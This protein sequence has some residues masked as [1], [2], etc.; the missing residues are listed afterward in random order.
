MRSSQG[1]GP[2]PSAALGT[3]LGN[4]TIAYVNGSLSVSP[5]SLTITA[6]AQSK[7]YGL[8]SNLGTTAFTTAGLVNGDTVTSV[9]LTGPATATV[10][11]SPYPITGS[12]ATGTE[13]GNYIISYVNGSLTV[14]PAL[15]TITA[16]NRSKTYRQMNFTEG[17]FT[18]I[19]LQNSETVGSV[20][21][22]SVRESPTAGVGSYPIVA[23]CA[24]GGTFNPANHAISYVNGTLTVSPAGLTI[25]SQGLSAKTFVVSVPTANGVVYVLESIDNLGGTNWVQVSSLTGN[26]GSMTLSDPAATS[27]SRFY[28]VKVGQ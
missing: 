7:T 4:Y 22:T 9:N 26:G 16:D 20:V 18:A 27:A 12:A 28:R 3:G 6:S 10:A 1:G 21:L 14:N 17:G 19:G 5:A 8:T 11:G 15:L 25:T 13:L 23:C 24:A 2:I